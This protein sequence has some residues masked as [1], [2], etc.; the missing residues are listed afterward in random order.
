VPALGVDADQLHIEDLGVYRNTNGMIGWTFFLT[1]PI[2]VTGLGWYDYGHDGLI[3]SHQIGIWKDLSGLPRDQLFYGL[4]N[5]SLLASATI[6]VGTEAPLNGP[7]RTV[8]IPSLTLQ[9]GGYEIAGTF[10]SD[11]GDIFKFASIVAGD[12]IRPDPRIQIAAPTVSFGDQFRA[13]DQGALYYG[14]HLG[15]M[16]FLEIP[17]PAALALVLLAM[18]VTGCRRQ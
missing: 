1:E 12:Q 18:L 16:L 2:T 14:V 10:R 8:D 11:P 4:T 9:P 6:A 5:M 7:W 15:P 13:P 17:E 3:D